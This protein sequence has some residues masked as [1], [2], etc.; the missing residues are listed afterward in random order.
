M[1]TPV[2]SC[3]FALTPFRR[4]IPLHL[5]HFT[6]MTAHTSSCTMSFLRRSPPM[7]PASLLDA[8]VPRHRADSGEA[9]DWHPQR[10]PGA[11]MGAEVSSDTARCA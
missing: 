10:E 3:S 11:N 5:R 2:G 4:S 6:T 7:S 8:T 9:N 1:T